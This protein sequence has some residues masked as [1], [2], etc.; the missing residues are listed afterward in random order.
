V[1]SLVSGRVLNTAGTLVF[2]TA[3]I[4]AGLHPK[5]INGNISLHNVTIGPHSALKGKS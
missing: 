3:S 4:L 2:F 1:V 5:G